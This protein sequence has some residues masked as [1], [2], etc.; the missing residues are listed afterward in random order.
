[1][2]LAHP[3]RCGAADNDAAEGEGQLMAGVSRVGDLEIAQDMDYQRRAWMV[4]RVSWGIIALVTLAALLGLLGGAGPFN[5]ASAG[6]QDGPLSAEYSRFARH[7]A[8]T[9]LRLAI[10]PGATRDGEARLWLGADFLDKIEVQQVAPEPDQ[11][12][13][14]GDRVWFIYRATDLDR[15]APVTITYQPETIGPLEARAGLADDA[16][17]SASQFIYP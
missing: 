14:A 8:P 12:E 13:L 5:Q 4:Q 1:M 9:S 15:P 2:T 11:I 16:P 17:L 7:Q 3:L 6:E 10:G